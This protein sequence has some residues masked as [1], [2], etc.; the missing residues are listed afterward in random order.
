MDAEILLIAS[1]SLVWLLCLRTF[2]YYFILI[3]RFS[4]NIIKNGTLCEA[5]LIDTDFRS[6]ASVQ[7]LHKIRLIN[8]RDVMFFCCSTYNVRLKN[9]NGTTRRVKV[10]SVEPLYCF[11]RIGR[12]NHKIWLLPNENDSLHCNNKLA[13]YYV[14]TKNDYYNVLIHATLTT[15]IILYLISRG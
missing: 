10:E 3:F 8:P 4:R 13:N 9:K 14:A 7:K 15:G 12:K 2:I 1:I 5:E 11:F 6:I